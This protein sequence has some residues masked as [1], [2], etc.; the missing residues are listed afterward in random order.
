MIKDTICRYP[1]NIAIISFKEPI[2]FIKFCNSPIP[3]ICFSIC[4]GRTLL[5]CYAFIFRDKG[6]ISPIFKILNHFILLRILARRLYSSNISITSLTCRPKTRAIR[7][8]RESVMSFRVELS[9]YVVSRNHS[10]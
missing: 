8:I 4:K 7:M 2:C 10:A 6:L 1:P 5:M 9:D 3:P